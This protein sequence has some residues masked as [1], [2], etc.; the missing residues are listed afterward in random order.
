[1]KLI[2]LYGAVLCH[3]HSMEKNLSL[4]AQCELAQI[5]LTITTTTITTKH[6]RHRFNDQLPDEPQLAAYAGIYLFQTRSFCNKRYKFFADKM[7]FRSPKQPRQS[8]DGN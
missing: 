6:Y 1:M 4:S 3:C 5:I 2:S 7:P 8:T